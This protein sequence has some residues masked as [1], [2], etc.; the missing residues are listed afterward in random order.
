MVPLHLP[1]ELNAEVMAQAVAEIARH[2]GDV[3]L[4]CPWPLP[5]GWMVTGVGWAAEERG[6][7]RASVL[8]VTG[9][10]ALAGGPADLLLV[11]EYPGVGL[12]SRY[13]GLSGL[14]PGPLVEA[15]M[16]LDPP[17]ARVKAGG[18][19]APLWALPSS[20]DRSVYAGEAGAIWLVAVL[21]PA[22]A[23]YL[24]ADDPE[25]VDVTE[26]QPPEIGYGA[27]SRRLR[28]G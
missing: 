7:V 26:W 28:A 17:H 20:E 14:D 19:P 1:D 2:A 12:A 25:L 24:F 21:W 11:A 23:G 6:G 18:R 16:A 3:P 4:W 8:A 15:A 13:A 9:P 5:Y 27:P 10:A 22:S